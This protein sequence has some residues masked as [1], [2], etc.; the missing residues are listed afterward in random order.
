MAKHKDLELM[1]ESSLHHHPY[2]YLSTIILS[3]FFLGDHN[4]EN[5]ANFFE[6][7]DKVNVQLLLLSNTC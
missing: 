2:F 7:E 4:S 5:L 3:T 1:L 6:P